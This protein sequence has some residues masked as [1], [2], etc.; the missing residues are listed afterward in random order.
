MVVHALGEFDLATAQVLADALDQACGAGRDVQLDM[1]GVSFI[2][3][4]TLGVVVKA[5]NALSEHGCRIEIVRPTDCVARLLQLTGLES[6]FMAGAK[7]G[8]GG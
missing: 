1:S 8:T 5:R 7:H 6:L 4:S 2:D 3:A